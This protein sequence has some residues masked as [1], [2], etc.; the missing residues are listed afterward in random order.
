MQFRFDIPA[1][2]YCV[3]ILS[4]SGSSVS[5]RGRVFIICRYNGFTICNNYSIMETFTFMC[6]VF[7]EQFLVFRPVYLRSLYTCS[8]V[9][10][11]C[12]IGLQTTRNTRL[13]PNGHCYKRFK[14]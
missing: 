10:V 11:Y 14:G 6:G 3:L 9:C 13:G 2:Y 5:C 12:S 7:Y 1:V 8:S 4:I